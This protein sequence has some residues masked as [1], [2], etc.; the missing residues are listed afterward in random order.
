MLIT[1]ILENNTLFVLVFLALNWY[2]RKSAK[3]VVK[4]VSQKENLFSNKWSI[5]C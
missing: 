1:L 4:N 5:T 3:N 2:L